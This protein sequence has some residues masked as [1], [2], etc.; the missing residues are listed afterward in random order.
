VTAVVAQEPDGRLEKRL[1]PGQVT[2]GWSHVTIL[3]IHRTQHE[4]HFQEKPCRRRPPEPL[5]RAT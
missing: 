3:S 4:N 1:A 2:E 5:A